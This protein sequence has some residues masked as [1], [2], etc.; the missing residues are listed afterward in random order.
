M[1]DE[2]EE[3]GNDDSVLKA[4]GVVGVGSGVS[5]SESSEVDGFEYLHNEL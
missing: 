5:S 3:W 4:F 1:S 2:I